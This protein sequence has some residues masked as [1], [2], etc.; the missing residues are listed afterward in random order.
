MY[1]RATG[2]ATYT[3]GVGAAATP[4]QSWNLRG[5]F[6]ELTEKERARADGAPTEHV[7]GLE[8]DPLDVTFEPRV[9]DVVETVEDGV[10]ILETVVKVGPPDVPVNLWVQRAG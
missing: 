10:P 6:H 7:R 8:L 4:K 9:G 3:P 2:R 1:R 5:F